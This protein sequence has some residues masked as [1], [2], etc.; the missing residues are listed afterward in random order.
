MHLR[1]L[2]IR[3]FRAISNIGIEFTAP[4]S[5]IVGPN[6][7]GKTTILEG[8]SSCKGHTVATS[9]ERGS[10]SADFARRPCPSK[11]STSCR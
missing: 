9:T 7:I 8:N 4:V 2:S 5:V 6:A 1:T 3:N 10:T 11:S